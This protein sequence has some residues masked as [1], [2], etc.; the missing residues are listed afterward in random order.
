MDLLEKEGQFVARFIWWPI[1]SRGF[2][3]RIGSNIKLIEG[4]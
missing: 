4:F 2:M 3:E 1:D